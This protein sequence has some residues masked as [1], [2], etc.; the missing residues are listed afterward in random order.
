MS[1]KKK[2]IIL[3]G[4]PRQWGQVQTLPEESLGDGTVTLTAEYDTDLCS[5]GQANQALLAAT[6]KIEP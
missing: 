1:K 2:V 3:E 6:E 4:D 5:D